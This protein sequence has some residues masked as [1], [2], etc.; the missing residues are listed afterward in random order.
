[1][2][3]KY[4]QNY[5]AKSM[6][7]HMTWIEFWIG[8]LATYRLTV[9][10]CRCAGPWQFFKRL[11]EGFYLANFFRCVFCVS[12][13]TAAL[14]CVALYFAGLRQS[15]ALWVLLVF[16]FSGVTIALDRVFSADHQT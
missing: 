2:P 5:F 8:S 11:R 6:D 12:V 13:Y 4:Q 10:I 14:V 9:L 7:T 3:D 16:A 15:F 1:M